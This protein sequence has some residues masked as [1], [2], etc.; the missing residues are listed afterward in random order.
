MCFTIKGRRRVVKSRSAW[1]QSCV[2]HHNRTRAPPPQLRNCIQLPPRSSQTVRT[3]LPISGKPHQSSNSPQPG[4]SEVP[5]HASTQARGQPSGKLRAGTLGLCAWGA[6]SPRFGSVA[7]RPDFTLF[8]TL[9]S[10]SIHTHSSSVSMAPPFGWAHLHR[11]TGPRDRRPS[12]G[13]PHCHS[14]KLR[15]TYN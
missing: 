10:I 7:L 5:T 4:Q 9:S 2:A 1:G 6:A 11:D 8:S 14:K 3:G 13:C 15:L 12:L